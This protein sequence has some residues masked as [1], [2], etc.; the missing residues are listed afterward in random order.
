MGMSTDRNVTQSRCQT[1][2]RQ[3]VYFHLHTAQGQKPE[4]EEWVPSGEWLGEAVGA[5][6][7]M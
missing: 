2:V 6:I 5:S 4:T 7:H 3:V 1:Q